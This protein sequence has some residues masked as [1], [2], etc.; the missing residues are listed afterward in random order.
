MRACMDCHAEH[1]APND[2][3]LCHNHR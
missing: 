2:C 1:K 3:D